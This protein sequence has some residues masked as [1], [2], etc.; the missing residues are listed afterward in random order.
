VAAFPKDDVWCREEY[1]GRILGALTR[2]SA[3]AL[4]LILFGAMPAWPQDSPLAVDNPLASLKDQ[5]A[6]ALSDASLPF[7]EEQERAIVLMMEERR[8]ASETLF[9]DLMNFRA[10]PTSGQEAD[11]LKSAIEWMRGEFATRIRNYLTPEQVVIWDRVEAAGRPV[12]AD[13]V[14]PP[15]ERGQTQFVRISNNSFSVESFFYGTGAAFAGGGGRNNSGPLVI[16]RGGA[17]AWHGNAEY[18]MKDEALNARNPFASNKPPYQERQFTFNVGGPAVPGKLTSNLTVGYNRSEN[19]GTVRATLPN[20]E[21]FALGITR[22]SVSRSVGLDNNYQVSNSTSLRANLFFQTTANENQ[23]I[24]D[25]TLPERA[26]EYDGR[27]HS[28]DF[29]HFSALSST[30]ILETRIQFSGNNNKGTPV[31]DAVRINVPDAFQSGGAQNRYH[32]RDRTIQFGAL[33]TQFGEILTLKVGTTGTHRLNQAVNHGNFGGTFD[34]DSL[35]DFRAGTPTTYR[36]NR[37]IPEL[38]VT[39]LELG[40]FVQND[41]K[42]T[43]QL[44]VMAGLRYE[45]QTNLSDRNNLIPRLGF[46]YGI[47]PATVIRGGIG[48]Y[49]TRLGINDVETQ[50]RFDGLHQYEIVIDDPSYPDPFLAGSLRE[51]F[52]SVRVWD[53]DLQLP[54]SF[55]SMISLER[56]FWRTFLLTT[57]YSYE[58]EQNRFRLRNLNAPVDTTSAVLRACQPG[59]SAETCR[60]PNPLQGN[61]LNFESTGKEFTHNFRVNVRYRFSIFNVSANYFFQDVQGHGGTQ[62]PADN[63]DLRAE[64]A[65]NQNPQHQGGSTINAQLPL[66]LFLSGTMTANSGRH[67]SIT[68]GEDDNQ[69]TNTSDRPPG[70]PR[71]SATGPRYLNF[72]FNLSKAFYLNAAGGGTRKNVNAFLNLTNAFNRVHYGTPSGVLSSPSFG[73][74]TSADNPRQIEVGLRFQF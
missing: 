19:V 57:S 74:S 5:L 27:Y 35:D 18:L 51:T 64:W 30:R 56:T 45:A 15:R 22:P 70:V 31:T 54:N 67:Y 28:L 10:G 23:G 58:R 11:R 12:T 25:F 24:G 53:P 6:R 44:T 59:Q 1:H 17:G 26:S 9:G 8:Q 72:D 4:F 21:V 39:Q 37:G 48:K 42:V 40:G 29:R 49:Y 46:A 65:R 16:E 47:G 69:D 61:L 63:F 38:E 71:N 2:D 41:V 32:E 68:T 33:Y 14:Q 66:G 36:V 55:V 34:F 60:R 73:Q 52:P 20:N 7:T 3:F 50:R 43:Q 62:L 13:G